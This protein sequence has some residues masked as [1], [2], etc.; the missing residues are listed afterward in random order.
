MSTRTTWLALMLMLPLMV[1]CKKPTTVSGTVTF[2]GAEVQQGYV[3]FFPV[4][5]VS[6]TKGGDIV[7]GKYKVMGLTPGPKRVWITSTPRTQIEG[8]GPGGKP[9]VKFLAPENSIPPDAVGND[10]NV[11]I[12]PGQ[13]QHDFHLRKPGSP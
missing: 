3:T 5:D 1:G 11:L 13:Q 8:L 2:E 9:I 12:V 4:G 7:A 6:A 10:Q